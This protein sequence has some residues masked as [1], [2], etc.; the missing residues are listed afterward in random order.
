MLI[1]EVDRCNGCGACVH[2]CPQGA[3]SLVEGIAR[4][5]SSSCV[6]CQT[7]VGACPA[8]AI[9]VPMPIVR[10]EEAAAALDEERIPVATVPR[11]TL[12]TL[13][14]ATFA[15]M[16]RYVLPRAAEVLMSALE[17]RPSPASGVTGSSPGASPSPEAS[18]ATGMGGRSGGR[19]QRHRG[20]R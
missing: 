6:E 16:G 14:A 10:R 4:I 12:A 7:C 18:P 19:R 8:G 1:I 17:R 9:Q 13:A 2:A 20:G 15:F 5:D 11:G 3:I